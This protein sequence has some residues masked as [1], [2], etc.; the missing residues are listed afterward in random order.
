MKV[1]NRRIGRTIGYQ[2]RPVPKNTPTKKGILNLKGIK[3]RASNLFVWSLVLVNVILI[4]SLVQ[5]LFS[6]KGITTESNVMVENTLSVVVQNGCGVKGVGIT[7]SDILKSKKFDV[8]SVGN[9]PSFDYE[10]SVIIDPGKKDHKEVEKVAKALGIT[11]DQILQMENQ[12]SP[13]DV[14]FIIGQDYKNLSSY[15]RH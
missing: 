6:S 10:K 3:K 12:D 4:A 9:A 2:K 8:V 14:T 11:A 1:V 7:F 15:K 13:G 5:K